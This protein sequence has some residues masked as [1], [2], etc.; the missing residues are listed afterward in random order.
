[1]RNPEERS[2][3]PSAP[4]RISYRVDYG[5]RLMTR[6]AELGAESPDRPVRGAELAEHDGL[7]PSSV[8]DILRL[9]RNA[10]LVRSQRGGGGGWILAR[11][12]KAITVAQVIR[13]IE[14]PLSVVRGVRPHDLAAEGEREP[15]ISLWIAVRASLRSVLEA[16]TIAHLA[17][18][19]LPRRITA[20][21]ADPDA[22][23][24]H[25]TS[26]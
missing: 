18:G 14:G 19:Q 4:V 20:L 6:L 15:F 10:G 23:E 1:M 17:S 22:W 8:D 2:D 25:G 26:A 3:L 24:A 21:L 16:V 12:A 11:P 9:L 5:V 7:P 13:A